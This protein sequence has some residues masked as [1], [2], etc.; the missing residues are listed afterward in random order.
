MMTRFYACLLACLALGLV[1]GMSTP[2]R[3][4]ENPTI[5]TWYAALAA[6]DREKL[7]ELLADDAVIVLEDLGIE[8]TKAE[9]IAALDE[10][11]TAVDGAEIRHRIDGAENGMTAVT[12]CY[13]FPDNQLLTRELFAIDAGHITKTIQTSIADDCSDL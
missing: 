2:A 6:S 12:V 7:G 3:A 5:S 1:A 10:W 9:F 4:D 8:Q 13:D 11:E